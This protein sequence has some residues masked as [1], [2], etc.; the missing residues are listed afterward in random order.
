MAYTPWQ[1]P[2]PQSIAGMN[3]V[4]VYGEN[5]QAAVGL[6]HQVALGSNLQICVNPSVLADLCGVS[7]ATLA[8]IWGSGPGGNHQMT[9]GSNTNVVWGRQYQVNLGPNPVQVNAEK[10]RVV[11]EIVCGLIA[12]TLIAWI[13]VYGLEKDENN[14]ANETIGFQIAVDVLLALLLKAEVKY[15]ETEQTLTSA[16]KGMFGA[17]DL[18]Q[19]D[20]WQDF[21]QGL[22][23][24][25]LLG[26]MIAPVVAIATE[27]G[28]FQG[29]TQD[30]QFGLSADNS[31]STGGS[32]SSKP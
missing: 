13:I 30:T 15:G 11:T 25:V 22:T 29:E 28:H 14:R 9:I 24:A 26:A 7:S 27:E 8:S 4:V 32:G 16:L 12:A 19:S 23:L 17:G 1:N 6:N 21:G 5:F 20:A 3:S 18:F 10:H 2:D 31:S